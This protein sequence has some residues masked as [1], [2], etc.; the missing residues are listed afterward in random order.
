MRLAERWMTAALGP[1]AWWANFCLTCPGVRMHREA[2]RCWAI[3]SL[4][5]R[6]AQLQDLCTGEQVRRP[7][8]A[9]TRR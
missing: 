2:S 5:G 3:Q 6:G 8:H 7:S 1:D 4:Q 9:T